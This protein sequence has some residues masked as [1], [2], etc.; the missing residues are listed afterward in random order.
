[1]LRP[2]GSVTFWYGSGS[3]DP[4]L[5]LTDTG[6]S[7]TYWS[8]GSGSATLVH[9]H[10]S[11][12]IS[13]ERSHKTVGF[14][15]YYCLMTE[16]WAGYVRV[17]NGSGCGSGRPKNIRIIHNT[18]KHCFKALQTLDNN[19]CIIFRGVNSSIKEKC[20]TLPGIYIKINQILMTNGS[21]CGS[22]RPK[23]IRIL[24]IRIRNTAKHCSKAPENLR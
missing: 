8:Y 6:G 13:H 16:G 14:S 9:L 15:Y 23:S 22:G 10:H 21:G 12:K 18:A 24:R 7:K 1:M 2:C 19:N 20:S 4:Y 11:S 3:S 5:W 17:T